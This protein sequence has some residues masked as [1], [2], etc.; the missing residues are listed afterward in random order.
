LQKG[1]FPNNNDNPCY[2]SEKRGGKVVAKTMTKKATAFVS[3]QT[4]KLTTKVGSCSLVL[5]SQRKEKEEKGRRR[6]GGH[7]E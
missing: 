1:R 5:G 2:V 4:R 6:T 3:G 7:N